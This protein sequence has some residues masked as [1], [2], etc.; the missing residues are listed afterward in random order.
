VKAK[1]LPPVRLSPARDPLLDES[2]GSRVCGA[3]RRWA[4]GVAFALAILV[5]GGLLD[6]LDDATT[7]RAQAARLDSLQQHTERLERAHRLRD[8]AGD[9]A[10]VFWMAEGNDPRQVGQ[11]LLNATIALD[12]AR[13]GLFE[14]TTAKLR[15]PS[16]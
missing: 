1:S 12:S 9:C 6:Q 4:F 2:L 11:K 7:I 3:F 10:T 13:G 5:A 8:V 16:Q 15:S 14:T